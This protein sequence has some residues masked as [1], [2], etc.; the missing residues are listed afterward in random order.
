MVAFESNILE[1][2]G[3]NSMII[4]ENSAQT[5]TVSMEN[6]AIRQP[7][8]YAILTT[9]DIQQQQLD[10]L[11][12]K[13]EKNAFIQQCGGVNRVSPFQK[14]K[15]FWESLTQQLQNKILNLPSGVLQ[16]KEWFALA[17]LTVQQ[18]V[19]WCEGMLTRSKK[20][21]SESGL[22]ILSPKAWV[23]GISNFLPKSKTKK[24][25]L[26][27]GEP[28]ENQDF[29]LLL[30][31]KTYDFTAESLESFIA[32]VRS[33]TKGKP[34]VTEDVLPF[35]KDRGLN[36]LL[37]LSKEDRIRFEF[38]LQLEEKDKDLE[39]MRSQF[40]EVQQKLHQRDQQVQQQQQQINQLTQDNQ[41]LKQQN[42]QQQ[43]QIDKLIEK[44]EAVDQFMAS[45]ATV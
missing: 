8:L 38:K 10:Q 13:K 18:V 30:Q 7:F 33:E 9:A 15:K 31:K 41:Q 14:F 3:I 39:N 37:I 23:E 11:S 1:I 32:Q 35:L 2:K 29:N 12:D 28:L 43:Q 45:T 19:D 36:P 26:K 21:K 25:Y 27:L 40:Q 20:Q 4:A 6:L 16:Q 5:A 44:M 24:L 42:Q 17:K 22:N 34:L